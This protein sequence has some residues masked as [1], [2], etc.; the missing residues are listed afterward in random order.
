VRF[1]P[2]W[3]ACRPPATHA[4]T[5][6]AYCRWP[7]PGPRPRRCDHGT[8][9]H[10]LFRE[11]R[12]SPGQG[13][14]PGVRPRCLLPGKGPAPGFHFAGMRVGGRPSTGLIRRALDEVCA[15]GAQDFSVDWE[16]VAHRRRNS[17]SATA[18]AIQKLAATG[19]QIATR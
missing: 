19:P 10:D 16:A 12:D 15:P 9:H 6:S 2:R 1:P 5:P 7:P 18:V 17:S 3:T 8:R 4:T 13:P 14:H 11:I